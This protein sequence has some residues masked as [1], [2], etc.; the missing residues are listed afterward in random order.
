MCHRLQSINTPVANSKD[1]SSFVTGKWRPKAASYINTMDFT[2]PGFIV[3]PSAM[4]V[5]H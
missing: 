5:T 4:G 2:A 3:S 1:L